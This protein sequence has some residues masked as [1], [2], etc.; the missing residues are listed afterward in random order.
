MTDAF[1]GGGP[2]AR[3]V[4]TPVSDPM[5]INLICFMVNPIIIG[6]HKIMATCQRNFQAKL[7]CLPD[8]TFFPEL[9]IT[10]YDNLSQFF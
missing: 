1:D 7:S 3:R 9:I 2:K 6:G 4:S 5:I 8:Q 10:S